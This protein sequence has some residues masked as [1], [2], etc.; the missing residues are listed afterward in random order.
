M[1]TPGIIRYQT[2]VIPSENQVG[3]ASPRELA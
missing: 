1:T 2:T 3:K